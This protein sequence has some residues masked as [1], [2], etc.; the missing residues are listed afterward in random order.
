[1][2]SP[3]FALLQTSHIRLLYIAFRLKGSTEKLPSKAQLFP[4][5]T[6]HYLTT[7]L[8][9]QQKIFP[10][11]QSKKELPIGAIYGT[12]TMLL[13]EVCRFPLRKYFCMASFTNKMPENPFH[14][15]RDT[16]KVQ[17]PMSFMIRSLK[18]GAMFITGKFVSKK[19]IVIY[20]HSCSLGFVCKSV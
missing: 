1:M 18:P 15:Y 16:A 5:W 13:S 4:V 20:E 19:H 6:G 17:Q 3:W 10:T 2:C 12:R 9:A 11:I 7:S 8:L 14:P